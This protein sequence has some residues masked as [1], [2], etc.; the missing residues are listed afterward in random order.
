MPTGETT[1][2]EIQTGRVRCGKL[3]ACGEIAIRLKRLGICVGREF[4]LV[5]AGDP[6]VLRIGES[7]VGISR[8]LAKLVFVD[9]LASISPLDPGLDRIE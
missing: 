1:L 7:Q 8:H 9:A 4:E 2:A 3:D 6:M 5:G